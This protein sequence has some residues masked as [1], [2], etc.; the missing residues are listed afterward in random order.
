M[1]LD[2]RARNTA[3]KMIKKFGKV[4]TLSRIT[5]GNYDP[6]TGDMPASSAVD[7]SVKSLIKDCKPFE[8]TSGT[9]ETGDK[10]V[11]LAALNLS[12]PSVGDKVTIDTVIYSVIS[13]KTIWSGELAVMFELQVR[14]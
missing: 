11:T 3:E 4:I 9:I 14:L 7:L 5:N 8:F 13:V 12:Q 6:A 2:T 1:T 10:K